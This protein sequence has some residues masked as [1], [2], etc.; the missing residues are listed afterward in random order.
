MGL[1]VL[2]HHPVKGHVLFAADFVTTL[3]D[4]APD[5]VIDALG[6]LF[7]G[8]FGRHSDSLS[9]HEKAHLPVRTVG[10]LI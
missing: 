2:F 10:S 5:L 8:G 6:H 4:L 1:K 3:G 7:T 9:V